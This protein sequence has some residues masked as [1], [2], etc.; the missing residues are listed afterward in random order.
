MKPY[1]RTTITIPQD[2]YR[3]TRV[4]AAQEQKSLSGFITDLLRKGTGAGIVKD[5]PLP[6][7]KYHVK[8][9]GKIERKDIYETYL[10][11]KVPS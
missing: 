9:R 8:G 10:R 2:L 5:T 3:K 11:R 4:Q 1:E 7:G 6:L